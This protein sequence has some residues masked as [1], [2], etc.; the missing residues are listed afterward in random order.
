MIES[1][2]T[3]KKEPWPFDPMAEVN[4]VDPLSNKWG[5]LVYQKDGRFT[6]L[7]VRPSDNE[8]MQFIVEINQPCI[9]I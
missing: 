5:Y 6:F 1:S 9:N 7:K 2:K 3:E 4:K 8:I